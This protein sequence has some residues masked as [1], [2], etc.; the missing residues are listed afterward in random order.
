MSERET[1]RLVVLTD[2]ESLFQALYAGGELHTAEDTIY[3]SDIEHAAK[4]RLMELTC[5]DFNFPEGVDKMPDRFEDVMPWI[6]KD[7][8]SHQ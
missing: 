2:Q 3:A 6:S 5:L 7:Q 8:E 4:G 1:V